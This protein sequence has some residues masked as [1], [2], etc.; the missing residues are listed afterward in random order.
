MSKKRQ[1]RI[2]WVQEGDLLKAVPVTLGLMENQYVEL[3]G[4]DLTEGQAVVTGLRNCQHAE[5]TQWN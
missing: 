3:L 1:H 4:G 5:V 2:V